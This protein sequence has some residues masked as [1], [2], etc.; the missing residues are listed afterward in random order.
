MQN[1]ATFI[2]TQGPDKSRQREPSV[3]GNM[4]VLEEANV[5]DS[6]TEKLTAHRDFRSSAGSI[7][8]WL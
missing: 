1:P 5:K 7:S 2:A 3:S 6:K 8:C 4:D